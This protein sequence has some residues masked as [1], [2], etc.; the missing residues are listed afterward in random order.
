MRTWENSKYVSRYFNVGLK[1][2]V[3]EISE[4]ERERSKKVKQNIE[5]WKLLKERTKETAR[6][7]SSVKKLETNF[8]TKK[9]KM[10][11]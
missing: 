1:K 10:D 5:S 11:S 3:K 7:K 6:R 9:T 8:Q 2:E 4:T